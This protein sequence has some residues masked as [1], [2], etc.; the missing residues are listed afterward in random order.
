[1]RAVYLRLQFSITLILFC[2]IAHAYK[3]SLGVIH[4]GTSLGGGYANQLGASV[5]GW[6]PIKPL[7]ANTDTYTNTNSYKT[8]LRLGFFYRHPSFTVETYLKYFTNY[9]ADWRLQGTNSGTGVSR[10]KGVGVGVDFEMPLVSKAYFRSGTM[11]NAEYI[12]NRVLN[13]FSPTAGAD[14][15]LETRSKNVLLGGGL[16]AETYLGDLWSLG[17]HAVYLFDIEG[18]WTSA[19]NSSFLGNNYSAGSNILDS[20]GE[21]LSSNLSHW[22]IDL[23]LRLAFY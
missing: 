13:S 17:M 8:P 11:L 10:Y 21:P 22:R 2:P 14:Q 3:T 19:K 15:K 1:M 5:D 9:Q 23:I 18:T 20:S 4:Y 12:S 7:I 6:D 16:F